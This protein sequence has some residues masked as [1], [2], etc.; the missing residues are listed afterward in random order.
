MKLVKFALVGVGLTSGLAGATFASA[1]STTV[2]KT[3][4]VV[5]A[6]GH[7]V[8]GMKGT[9]MMDQSAKGTFTISS[10]TNN[11]CYI[12]AAHKLG[13]VTSATIDLGMK[14]EAGM[15]EVTLSSHDISAGMMHFPCI[16]VTHM[17]AAA[18]LKR[19]TNY[20][21]Q[22][23]NVTYPHGAVRGQL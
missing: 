12:V 1:S 14:G 2:T 10:T 15:T 5:N 9:T 21:F 4:Y 6:N 7:S 22:I 16:K 8:A 13:M 11:V 23:A 17:L 19:P 20:Y 18:I 3:T